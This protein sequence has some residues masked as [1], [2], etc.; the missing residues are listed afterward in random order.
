MQNI[1][2]LA[3]FEQVRQ[4]L[5]EADKKSMIFLDIDDTIITP[6]SN[7]FRY[8]SKHKSLIDDIKNNMNNIPN[9]AEI[10]SVWRQNRKLMFVHNKWPEF[11]RD[12]KLA[13]LPIYALTQM[14]SGKFGLIHSLEEWRYNELKSIGITFVEQFLDQKNIEILPAD[15]A[16]DRLTPAVFYQGYF[17]TGNHSKGSVMRSILENSRPSKI[18]FVDDREDH[19][20]DVGRVCAEF[21]MEYLGIVYQGTSL[22]RSRSRDE[23]MDLQRKFLLEQVKWLEDDEAE[24]YLKQQNG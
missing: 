23:V 19:V 24:I 16:A 9:Y 3:D 12:I 15:I 17:M 4:K 11:I 14:R 10:L 20:K 13:G 6:K 1:V 8:H 21:G 22:I 7:M 2:T 18:F 5:V